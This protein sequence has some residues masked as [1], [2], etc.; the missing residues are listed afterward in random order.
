MKQRIAT[1]LTVLALAATPLACKKQEPQKTEAP[2]AAAPAAPALPAPEAAP[3][4]EALFKQ[5]CAVCH[6]DGGNIVK[7]GYTLHK[8]DLAARNIVKP[9]DIVHTMRNPGEGMTKFDAATVSDKDATAIAEYIL[10]TF[11]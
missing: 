1:A 2:P 4:G 6:P 3:T 11:K 9:E 5:H 8:K 10:A 7:P